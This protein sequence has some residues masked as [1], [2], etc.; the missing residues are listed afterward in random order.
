MKNPVI[1]I[2]TKEKVESTAKRSLTAEYDIVTSS[3]EKKKRCLTDG[4]VVMEVDR[5]KEVKL[6]P[7][8][9]VKNNGFTYEIPLTKAVDRNKLTQFFSEHPYCYDFSGKHSSVED[10]PLATCIFTITDELIKVRNGNDKERVQAYQLFTSLNLEE[11]RA[12]GVYFGERT[13]DLESDDLDSLMVS[14]DSGIITTNPKYRTDFITTLDSLFDPL[15][16]NAKTAIAYNVIVT[17][18]SVFMVENQILG[19]N[20]N[21]IKSTLQV[22]EDL[23]NLLLKSMAQKS[24]T[25]FRG[26]NSE[27]KAAKAAAKVEKGV[28]SPKA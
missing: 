24:V 17:D 5:A 12:I 4:L 23:Y 8:N 28:A 18:G 10:R 19:N 14:L 11:K 21:E 20:F 9:L 3:G 25:V 22:R 7:M 6:L 16:I 27:E 15:T 26:R 13:L 2:T 1:S